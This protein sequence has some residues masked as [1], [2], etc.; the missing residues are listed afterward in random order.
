MEVPTSVLTG[1]RKYSVFVESLRVS[2][3]LRGK[4]GLSLKLS[5][6]VTEHNSEGEDWL[7]LPSTHSLRQGSEAGLHASL[8]FQPSGKLENETF[9]SVRLNY[10]WTQLICVSKYAPTWSEWIIAA[11][12]LAAEEWK[13]WARLTMSSNLCTNLSDPSPL[14]ELW[15]LQNWLKSNVFAFFTLTLTHYQPSPATS[16]QSFILLDTFRFS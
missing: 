5:D 9:H 14:T 3:G 7:P 8:C 16:L 4:S 15:G 1:D 12:W 6:A 11:W 2:P 13:K 10:A